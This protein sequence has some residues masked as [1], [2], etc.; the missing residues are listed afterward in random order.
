MKKEVA[1]VNSREDVEY[2]KKKVEKLL[3]EG[4]T[5]HTSTA[6]LLIYTR[7]VPSD[8]S[9]YPDEEPF[10]TRLREEEEDVAARLGKLRAF[11]DGSDF[12][13]L[14]ETQRVFLCVQEQ[15]MRQYLIVLRDRMEHLRMRPFYTGEGK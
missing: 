11:M 1:I 8:T 6:N 12:K 10:K 3:N 7:Q 15:A 5:Y 4:Y 13:K 2:I 9:K 14:D